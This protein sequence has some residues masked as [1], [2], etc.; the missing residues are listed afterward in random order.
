MWWAEHTPHIGITFNS[1][2]VKS[3]GTDKKQTKQ[4]SPTHI[5]SFSWTYAYKDVHAHDTDRVVCVCIYTN[6]HSC[7]HLRTDPRTDSPRLTVTRLLR[8]VHTGSQA[9]MAGVGVGWGEEQKS[10]A[11]VL[12]RS[13]TC[14]RHWSRSEQVAAYLTTLTLTSSPQSPP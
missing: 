14:Q 6:M 5:F 10:S 8:H 12:A 4:K 2:I 1:Q 3:P 9:K 7:T 11:I 13:Q